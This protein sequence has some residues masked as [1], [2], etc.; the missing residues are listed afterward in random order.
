MLHRIRGDVN[1]VEIGR[2]SITTLTK[3]SQLLDRFSVQFAYGH[4]EILLNYA[5]IDQSAILTGILQ[6]GMT[7]NLE[8]LDAITPR[9]LNGRR[10]PFWVFNM[11]DEK[12]LRENG[13]KNV[14]AIG[15]PW[16]Y[17]ESSP[18]PETVKSKDKAL[19]FPTHRSISVEPLIS[20]DE[21][22]SKISAKYSKLSG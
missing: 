13:N 20:R 8:I 19:I 16:I 21:I 22:K 12:N 3:K 5:A 15:A 4:R 1:G 11:N 2:V 6:H 9:L 10:S 14:K 7:H 17:L 18:L